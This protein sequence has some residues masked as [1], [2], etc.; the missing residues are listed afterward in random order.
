MKVLSVNGLPPNLELHTNTEAIPYNPPNWGEFVN[1]GTAPNQTSAVGCAYISGM[2]GDWDAAAGGGPTSNGVYPVEFIVDAFITTSSNPTINF[3]LGSNYWIST[4]DPAQGGGP[5]PLLDTLV[6]P[7]DYANIS[8]T[9]AGSSNVD[10]IT[11]YTYSVPADPNVTY[12]WTATNGTIVSGQGTNE[13][14]VEWNGS[15]NIEV[16]LTDGGCQGT[17]DMDVTANPTAIDEAAGI[18]ASVYPNPSN[19]MFNLK[20]EN[21]DALNIR[22]MDVSGKVVQS[23][24]L[25]G[26]TLYALDM[27]NAPIGVYVLEIETSEGR[28]FKKL[29]KN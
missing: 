13:V 21:T 24:R 29:I 15:G 17:D 7:S 26:S 11:Q 6:I 12:A 2:G 3:F 20:L 5:I 9:I 8:T 23:E 14:V 18:N 19:G 4:V 1:G 10:P 28:T 16:D 22:I 25:A 27:Q